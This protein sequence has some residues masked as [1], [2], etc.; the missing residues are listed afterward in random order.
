MASYNDI[1]K[2][3]IARLNAIREKDTSLVA[4]LERQIRQGGYDVYDDEYGT[5]WT[6]TANNRPRTT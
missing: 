3:V 5:H 4:D 6:R 1:Q 2:L